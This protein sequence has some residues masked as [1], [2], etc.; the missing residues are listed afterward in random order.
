MNRSILVIICDFLLLSLLS[1]I[2]VED[3]PQQT[4]SPNQVVGGGVDIAA[5]SNLMQVIQTELAKER[6][7]REQAE[8][9][10]RK[11]QLERLK[12]EAQLREK[13]KLLAEKER[14][15]AEQNRLLTEAQT[16]AEQLQQLQRQL[17]GQI[18]VRE[19]QL[20]EKE[21]QLVQLQAQ[22]Q[23]ALQ[24]VGELQQAYELATREASL[25]REQ[26][27]LIERELAARREEARR[28][29]E[30]IKRVIDER[31]QVESEK[32]K[33]AVELAKLQTTAELVAQQ[34]EESR[35]R[36]MQIT[37]EKME[38]QRHAQVLASGV[39]RLA[40]EAAQLKQEVKEGV[41]ALA[42]RTE[43][44]R[45]RLE[46]QG[47][48]PV[49]AVYQFFRT[50]AVNVGFTAR[51]LDPVGRRDRSYGAQSLV[52]KL[53]DALYV[54]T[55]ISNTPLGEWQPPVVWDLVTGSMGVGM[56]HFP[57][58]K[59]YLLAEDPRIVL[60]P[61]T[62]Q[63]L[64]NWSVAI[65]D[66]VKEPARYERAIVVANQALER[67]SYY[68]EVAFK[69][70][71]A[72]PRYIRVERLKE[73]GLLTAARPRAG[74]LLLTKKGELLGLMINEEYAIVLCEVH[75]GREISFSDGTG[76]L[77]TQQIAEL[78]AIS[79]SGLPPYLR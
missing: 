51:V 12:L 33:Y 4:Q 79:R 57:V 7:A 14:Q 8:Q 32:Q 47:E 71:S 10:S 34:L 35:K 5:V 28:L 75:P 60:V 17:E 15:L 26:L 46:E 64:K 52:I 77:S 9:I 53:A 62:E 43:E 18:Q 73:P 31:L 39:S 54:V 65:I 78:I 67:E 23:T 50:N 36:I 72:N 61:A 1:F 49:N 63:M 66:L 21:Y 19:K 16:R 25:T 22:Q 41:Q 42:Q 56:A 37:Q 2:K 55:H 6:L 30:E 3:L 58:S 69:V 13:E 68:G 40:E 44:I 11:E 76:R 20:Q 38:L 59:V 70:D 27:A 48:W 24:R 29:Q 45:S 74:D